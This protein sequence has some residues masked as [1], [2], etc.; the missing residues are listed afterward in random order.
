MVTED[1]DPMI[2]VCAGPPLC[3]LQSDDAVRAQENG[4]ELCKRI[5]VHPDGT[6]IVR[7][8]TIN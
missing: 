7:E 2:I 8:R 5:I 3:L 6:E 4:C 1:D